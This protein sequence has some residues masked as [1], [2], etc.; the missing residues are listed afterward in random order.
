MFSGDIINAYLINLVAIKAVKDLEDHL[1]RKKNRDR[2]II[3]EHCLA[4]L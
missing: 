1:F 4:S 3:F 2:E